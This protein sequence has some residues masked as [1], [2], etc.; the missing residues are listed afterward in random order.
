MNVNLLLLTIILGVAAGIGAI[1]T[2][3]FDKI[4]T[5]ATLNGTHNTRSNT[6]D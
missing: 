6:N 4:A 1:A 3:Q 5:P 2:I